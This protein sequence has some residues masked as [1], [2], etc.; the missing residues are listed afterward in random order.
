[1]NIYFYKQVAPMG[2]EKMWVHGS[3]GRVE[4]RGLPTMLRR[5]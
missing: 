4:R 1:M 5:A 2:H 3:S